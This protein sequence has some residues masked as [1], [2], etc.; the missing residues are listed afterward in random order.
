MG[1]RIAVS[2]LRDV[3]EG[4]MHGRDRSSSETMTSEAG[5][6]IE[7]REKWRRKWKCVFKFSGIKSREKSRVG[8]Q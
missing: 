8:H 5:V 6:K 7:R 4:P 2:E 1:N 3:H